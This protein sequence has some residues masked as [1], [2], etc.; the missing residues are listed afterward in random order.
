MGRI[1]K[2][3]VTEHESC[4]NCH[5][6]SIKDQKLKQES[7]EVGFRVEEGVSCVVCHGAYKRWV[8]LHGFRLEQPKWRP[9]DVEKRKTREQKQR[10]FGMT[11]LWNPILRTAL[12]TSCHVG[13]AEQGKFVTHEMYAA[14]HP[15]LPGFEPAYF[16]DAMPRHWQYLREKNPVVQ[17]DQQFD[18]KEKEQ[19]K[20]ALVGVAVSLAESMRV[21]AQQCETAMQGKQGL[22]LANF[23]CYACHHDLK[24]DSRRQKSGFVGRPGR[25]PTRPWP[26]VLVR[27]AIEHAADDKAQADALTTELDSDLKQLRNGF[28]ARPF[29][30]PTAIK[31]A[32][33]ALT[34]LADKLAKKVNNKPCD[35]AAARKLLDRIPSLY[36]KSV[37]DYDSARQVAWAFD[38]I[39]KEV[40]GDKQDP[41]VLRILDVSWRKPLNLDLPAGRDG[42]I[43]GD[44]QGRLKALNEF[45]PEVFKNTLK[46]LA[47]HLEKK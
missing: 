31:K 33:D 40:A 8:L 41:E 24:A 34:Q 43:E 46:S 42:S 22:D 1:L 21:L 14:G 16:S 23:D 39:Y 15:P 12:C 17:K 47:N 37:L 45:D 44:L 7:Q 38:V 11:D 30:E 28:D 2:I 27:L 35:V 25:V 29:G 20:L 18:G 10:E 26:T 9:K 3:K 32:A 5:A 13:N 6:V 36:Q 4:L 19:T